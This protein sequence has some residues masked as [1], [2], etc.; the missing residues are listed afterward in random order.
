ME[1]LG[2]KIVKTNGGD[3]LIARIGNYEICKAAFEKA[4]FL[5]PNEHLQMRQG[6]RVILKIGLI[7]IDR[8][9]ARLAFSFLHDYRA[10]NIRRISRVALPGVGWCGQASSADD[11][12]GKEEMLVH[13]H[14]C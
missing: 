6:A 5:C 12:G 3:E 13:D 1:N 2:F 10:S 7:M 11:S 9:E 8:V 4:L 14:S